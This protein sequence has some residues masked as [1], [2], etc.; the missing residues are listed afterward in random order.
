MTRKVVLPEYIALWIGKQLPL[1]DLSRVQFR[2]GPR[3]PFWWIVPGGQFSGLT[4]WNRVYVVESCWFLEP[5]RRTTLELILHELVHVVQYRKNPIMFPLRYVIDH[6]RF[7]YERNLAEI[8][9][10]AI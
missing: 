4:L 10:R 6:F 5:I 8:D 9:A 3:I 7:G 1:G 2:L